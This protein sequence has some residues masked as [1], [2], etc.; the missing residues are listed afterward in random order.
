MDMCQVAAESPRPSYSCHCETLIWFPASAIAY[1]SST[2]GSSWCG[3][4]VRKVCVW[5]RTCFQSWANISDMTLVLGAVDVRAPWSSSRAL[6]QIRSSHTQQFS[7]YQPSAWLLFI[8]GHFLL[9]ESS[10]LFTRSFSIGVPHR[11]F[12]HQFLHLKNFLMVQFQ[13]W[14]EDRKQL[15][16]MPSIHVG[17]L[18]HGKSR[19]DAMVNHV[20]SICSEEQSWPIYVQCCWQAMPSFT[21]GTDPL[22]LS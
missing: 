6:K 10:S 9:L 17:E 16:S 12:L 8:E 20:G 4:G 21:A 15:E 22:Q 19:E 11:Q 2:R 14:K 13:D 18:T 3:T 7:S 1:P 5:R